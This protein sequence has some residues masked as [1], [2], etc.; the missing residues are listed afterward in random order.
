[1]THKPDPL[2]NIEAGILGMYAAIKIFHHNGIDPHKMMDVI[3]SVCQME[4]RNM[5]DQ[6]FKK[7]LQEIA[8]VAK[9]QREGPYTPQSDAMTSLALMERMALLLADHTD[10]LPP[11]EPILPGREGSG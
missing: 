6:Q 11:P 1:M 9:Q 3:V 7:N 5:N 10:K 8:E 4:G 2:D